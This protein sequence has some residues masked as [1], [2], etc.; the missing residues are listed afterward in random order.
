MKQGEK[1]FTYIELIV[2]IAIVGIIGVAVSAATFQILK[3]TERNGNH[4]TVVSQVQNAGYWIGRDVHMAQSITA[5]NLT[6][7]DFLLISWTEEDSGDEYQIVYTL[8][9]MLEGTFK[10]LQRSQSING[11]ASSTMLV[12][13]YIDP[14]VQKTK[15]QFSNGMLTLTV[16]ATVN[17]G[18]SPVSE[19]RTY[20]SAPRPE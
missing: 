14:D 12:A 13:Q 17:G 19:T 6:L 18:A 16:T 8:E 3:G 10:K 15:G 11:G 2:T 20:L 5:D 9:N 4:M 1:G 7:P